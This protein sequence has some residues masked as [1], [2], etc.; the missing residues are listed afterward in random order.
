MNTVNKN[1]AKLYDNVA[2]LACIDT[3]HDKQE[4]CHS[5]CCKHPQVSRGRTS[6]SL[7]QT[8]VQPIVR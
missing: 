7:S 4:L 1:D 5:G 3:D 8:N 6:Y 2:D